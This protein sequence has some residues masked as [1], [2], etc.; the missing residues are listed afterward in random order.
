MVKASN[1]QQWSTTGRRPEGDSRLEHKL[2]VG[3]TKRP[4]HYELSPTASINSFPRLDDTSHV[5]S[6]RR[7][8]WSLF[9]QL[10]SRK[11]G[12]YQCMTMP[13]RRGGMKIEQRGLLQFTICSPNVVLI[14]K[15]QGL[16]QSSRV[17]EVRD[18]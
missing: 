11:V 16:G 10:R 8:W 17:Y 3:V 7:R 15:F 1:G 12:E 5:V 13:S 18:P 2:P 4:T 9:R 6:L 14:R